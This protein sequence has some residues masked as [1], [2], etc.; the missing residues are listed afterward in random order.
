ML[1]ALFAKPPTVKAVNTLAL[2]RAADGYVDLANKKA[3]TKYYTPTI[4]SV[5]SKFDNASFLFNSG[6]I[7]VGAASEFVWTKTDDF[8]VEWWQYVTQFNDNNWFLAKG[9]GTSSCLKTYLS[10]LYL[11]TENNGSTYVATASAMTLNVWQHVA[12][13]QSGGVLKVYVDGVQKMTMTALGNFGLTSIPISWGGG[14][15]GYTARAYMDQ[16]RISGIARYISPFTPPTQ[17]FEVD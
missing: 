2:V 5:A 4:S 7:G 10:N 8:T 1:E 6:Y 13:V 12:L 17:K 11:Q 3:I 16:L 9:T 14:N 15:S